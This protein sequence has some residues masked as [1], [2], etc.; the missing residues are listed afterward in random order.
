[1]VCLSWLRRNKF[2]LRPSHRKRWA[3]TGGLK[4]CCSCT[5][6]RW[7]FSKGTHDRSQWPRAAMPSK[8]TIQPLFPE[9]IYN[10]KGPQNCEP[11]S[12]YG[13]LLE[14]CKIL[15]DI[16]CWSNENLLELLLTGTCRDWMSADNVLLK[17]LE[18]INTTAD[19]SLAEYLCSLLE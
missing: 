16:C 15:L 10:E 12:I 7:A 5:K 2:R 13:D 3:Q 14:I 1:M 8:H 17:T 18:S 6:V 19:C 9:S 4:P 11:S